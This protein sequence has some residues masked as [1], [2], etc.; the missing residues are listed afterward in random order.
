MWSKGT[1]N[2]PPRVFRGQA[3]VDASWY[4]PVI[5]RET[6]RQAVIEQELLFTTANVFELP[7]KK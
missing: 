7:P 1:N 5:F 4:Y 6:V 2:L 3:F